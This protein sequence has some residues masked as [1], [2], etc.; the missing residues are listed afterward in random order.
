MAEFWGKELPSKKKD[1]MGYS[2]LEW[3]DLAQE[4]NLTDETLKNIVTKI[5]Q[6]KPEMEWLERRE[7]PLNP[8]QKDMDPTFT[9]YIQIVEKF[10]EV[11]VLFSYNKH[12]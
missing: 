6:D 5:E 7:A 12:R 1:Y 11:K 4:M 8:T 9:V 2:D 3:D 10:A